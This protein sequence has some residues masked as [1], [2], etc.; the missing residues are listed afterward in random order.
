MDLYNEIKRS[1]YAWYDMAGCRRILFVGEGQAFCWPDGVTVTCVSWEQIVNGQFQETGFDLLLADCGFERLAE[2]GAVLVALPRYLVPQGRMLLAMNNPFG[3]RY[4]CGDR[5]PY[6]E[7]SFAGLEGYRLAYGKREDV[8]RGRMYGSGRMRRWMQA[9]GFTAMRFYSVLPDLEHPAFLFEE[10]F[11]PNED[12]TGRVF[13]FYNHPESVFLE[14]ENLYPMLLENGMFH[15]MANAYLVECSLDGRLSDV[16]HVTCSAERGPKY[17]L[18]TIIHA[19]NLVEKKPLSVAGEE[20]LRAVQANMEALSAQGIKV[21]PSQFMAGRLEMPFVTAQVGTFYLREL[22]KR[23]QE[24]FLR[25]MDHFAEL[26]LRSS[27]H[28]REDAGDGEGVLLKK[29]YFDMVPLNSFFADGEFMFFDQEFAID[30]YPANVLL[31]RMVGITYGSDKEMQRLLPIEVM[32]DRYG[33]TKYLGRWLRMSDEFLNDLRNLGKLHDVYAP[34]QRDLRQV[35]ANRQ[36]INYPEEEY[37]RLFVDIFAGLEDKKLVIFGSGLWAQQF[38]DGFGR[39][40][41]VSMVVDNQKSRWG[42]D[43]RGIPIVSPD[44]LRQWEP[45]SFKVLICIKGYQSVVRQLREMGIEDYGIFD[46][47][48]SYPRKPRQV[49]VPNTVAISG[50]GKKDSKA[51]KYHIGYIAGV[52]DLYHIGHLNMFRRA[53][54]QC[55]YLIVGVVSDEGVRKNKG[56]DPFIPFNERVELVRACQYVDEAHEIPLTYAGTREAWNL[57]HF[58]VQFSGSDYENDPYWLS[59]KDFLEK[60]GST[61]VF[62]PYTEQTSSTKLKAVINQR[63]ARKE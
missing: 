13:P 28:V 9:A 60:H 24:Q 51:K 26:I 4:F 23:D 59:E 20:R 58:D 31:T 45:G 22:L 19:E 38:M 44:E 50:E 16:E 54:E 32:Y 7:Q 8:F 17:G 34:H 40:H 55:D 1:L 14:E 53:K 57:Y 47:Q 18:Y 46:P 49:V 42:K 33:L 48:R 56:V 2:P 5:D 15:A 35:Y 61:M 37:Q 62:F 39:E 27:E 41:P 6:T 10:D 30:N 29:G 36:R 43:L 52:F 25:A 3:L 63:L 12:L 11:L 21:V